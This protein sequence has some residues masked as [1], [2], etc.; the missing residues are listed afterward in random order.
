M[1]IKKDIIW[2]VGAIYIMVLLIAILVVVRVVV[3]QLFEGDKWRSKA[4]TISQRDVVVHA[5]RGDI[6]AD[7]GRLLASSL[8]YYQIRMDFRASGLS[9]AVFR[10]NVD[11]LAL[12][13]SRFFKDK[14]AREYRNK[15]WNAKYHT[16]S[17]RYVL[18]NRRRINYNELK[19]IKK[20]PLFRMGKNKGGL[21]CEQENKRVQP[22]IDLATRT[23]GYLLE[24]E[25]KRHV[26]KVGIEG[27]F[28]SELK[29]IDGI[30]LMQKMS[31]RWLP[32]NMVDPKDGN[33]LITTID[34]NFQ[35]VAESA[36]H[37]QLI[38]YNAD[39]GSAILMEVK[40][41]AIKAIANLGF[42]SETKTYR[43]IYNYAIGEATE[44]GSTFK[45]ASVMA[46][47]EDGY[48]G[49]MDSIDTG[50]G[51]YSYYKEKMRDSHYGGF[52]KITVQEAFEKSSNVGISKLVYE[53]Y[54]N[55]PR[56][57]INRLYDFRL[58]ETLGLDIRGEGIPEIKYP[59][60]PTWSG[61]SLPW[62]SIGYSVKQTPLQTLTFYNAIANNGK[63]MKPR[64]VKELQ[65]HGDVI[66]RFDT[67]VL[68][69]KICS[70]ETL[71]LVK[72]M[73]EGV[74]LRGTARNL[75]N[76]SYKIAGK[77]G[78]AQIAD[79]NKGYA[80]KV[81]QASFV[82]YFPADDPM[83]SCIVVI[84]RPNK[85]KG[86]Y[87]NQVAGPV[88]KTIA[89]KVYAMTYSMHPVKD[90]KDQSEPKVPLSLNGNKKDL[91]EVFDALNFVVVNKEIPSRWV[92]TSRKDSII[93]YKYRRVKKY[94]VPNVKGMG[95]QDAL[96]ILENAGLK[97][98]V[99]GIG[100]VNSQ[101]IRPGAY[102]KKGDRITIGLS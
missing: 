90:R 54:K 93:E 46:L 95:I 55:K 7:D 45:L 28:E 20:F 97:V 91:D 10:A 24:G 39:H 88:F 31:G 41:G 4:Q 48:V 64:F 6:C 47:L 13:L 73:L 30:S 72:N 17:N 66:Q 100:A 8:P 27:A 87:G 44:P 59:D 19:Q 74:V 43:E 81:Y 51:I 84:N 32:V 56:S 1:P 69:S 82:G 37:Q 5:N 62:M 52:G 89:D 57:F 34:V 98:T 79:N 3:L 25:G 85:T 92:M 15:L 102:F 83:Y 65:Y 96:Y 71:K 86:F 49:P 67:E 78:T 61:V 35:D 42:D 101:S 14:S 75:R 63:M 38:K 26:G 22:H 94:L 53:H 76:T 77:T 21:I 70:S 29:G 58:N 9:D 68:K 23:I 50:N 33:D 18:I 80:H 2:R 99:R 36:L 60:D 40:T 11:S 16:K 12:K